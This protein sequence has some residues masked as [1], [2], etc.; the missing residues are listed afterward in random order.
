MSYGDVINRPLA[1]LHFILWKETQDFVIDRSDLPFI[2][3]YA[4]EQGHY[5]LCYRRDVNTVRIIIV[6]PGVA[7]DKCVVPVCGDLADIGLLLCNVFVQFLSVHK[8]GF[9]Y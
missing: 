6:V 9:L 3:R 4:D 8:R 5:A 1:P 2:D 7:I